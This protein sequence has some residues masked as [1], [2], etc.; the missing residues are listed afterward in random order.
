MRKKLKNLLAKSKLFS[1]YSFRD[2]IVHTDG[3]GFIDS[4]S[5][6]DEVYIYLITLPCTL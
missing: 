1:F 4:T 5:D 2:L 6:P 3:H